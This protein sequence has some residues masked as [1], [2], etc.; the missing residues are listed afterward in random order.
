[1]QHD[2]SGT[3]ERKTIVLYVC[4]LSFHFLELFGF[5]IEVWSRTGIEWQEKTHLNEFWDVV[6]N[7]DE[8]V[9]HNLGKE[10]EEVGKVVEVVEQKGKEVEQV[11]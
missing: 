1:M 7:V 2:H 4:R 11:E 10:V 9:K 5:E 6:N 3:S 8:H